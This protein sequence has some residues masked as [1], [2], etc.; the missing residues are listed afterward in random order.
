MTGDLRG[1]WGQRRSARVAGVVVAA[2]LALVAI[3]VALNTLE[4]PREA[5]SAVAYLSLVWSNR[6]GH[7][8]LEAG[9]AAPP[10]PKTR[11]A[12][13][14]EPLAPV[15]E[16]PLASS[17]H[18]PLRE[19]NAATAMPPLPETTV[20]PQAAARRASE[21]L[22]LRLTEEQLH[23]LE[24]ERLALPSNALRR[25]PATVPLAG[26]EEPGGAH[27]ITERPLPHG[28]TEVHLGQRCFVLQP[29][30]RA[31]SDPFNH[32]NETLV[33]PC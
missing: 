33:H 28:E 22:I 31:R 26:L 29:S 30:A 8:G 10:A 25:E 15:P 1:R 19:S 12:P 23:M 6:A 18:R 14:E 20:A 16:L 5:G 17:R 2:H 9:A 3:L 21:P 4:I 32:A 7:P 27:A 13:F 24:G 11:Q